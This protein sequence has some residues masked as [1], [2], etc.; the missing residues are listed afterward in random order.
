MICGSPCAP[1]PVPTANV[2]R[3]WSAMVICA[4]MPPK[5]MTAK[6]GRCVFLLKPAFQ[7]RL[8]AHLSNLLGECHPALF[9][10]NLPTLWVAALVGVG[11][12]PECRVEFLGTPNFT[13]FRLPL[14]GTMEEPDDPCKNRAA[15]N[16]R[17]STKERSAARSHGP[18]PSHGGLPRSHLPH[19]RVPKQTAN[20]NHR[21]ITSGSR[22]SDSLEPFRDL[23][24]PK[25]RSSIVT[26]RPI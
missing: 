7:I 23:S 18:A 1:V 21:L 17:A 2:P 20:A 15:S 6:Q 25:I 4:A 24:K 13:P 9:I 19:R 16:R 11:A 10:E 22:K 8:W 14:A 3:R 12:F 5:A 26:P